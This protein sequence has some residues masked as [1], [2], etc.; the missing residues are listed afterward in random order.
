MCTIPFVTWIAHAAARFTGPRGAVTEQAQQTGCSRQCV[1]DHSQKVLAAVEAQHGGGPTRE[2][3]IQENQAL[4]RENAQLWDWLFQTIEFPLAKQQEFAVTALAMGLSL[5][6]TLVLLALLSG[7]AAAPG[8]SSVHRWVQAA[9]TAAG[10]V[11]KRLDQAARTSVLV[12]CLDEIFFHRRPVLVGVEPQS[13]VW[14]LATKAADRKGSTWSAALQPWTALGYVISD[15]GTGLQAGIDQMNRHRQQT[16]G[17]PM[18]KGLDVFHTKQ[19]AHRVLKVLWSR[20]ERTWE[21]AEAASRA[22][23]E[24]RRQGRDARGPAPR[25]RAAWKKAETAFRRYEQGEAAWKCAEPALS[26]FRPDGQLNDRSWA[27]EQLAAALP[28][29]SG[30]DWSKVR[31]LLQVPE[32]FTFLD[33]LHGALGQ[34]AVA[35]ELLGASVHLWWLRRQRRR[36]GDPAALGGYRQVAP[37]VQQLLCQRLDPN[38]RESYRRVA[39]VLGRAVRASGAVECMN[40]VLRMHQCRHRTLT[41]GMLDLKR[42][43]WNTRAFRGGKRRGRCPYEHLG[44]VLPSYRF[45]SL[46]Q[47]E[48]ITAL[49]EAKAKAKGIAA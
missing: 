42:L 47:D 45:W 29:L 33:R 36:G 43:Y 24:A 8:R 49:D 20:A 41:Q 11:L 19:E 22:R 32:S 40:S 7:A 30:S 17:A 48:L 14:F 34:L 18:E 37:L 13:M 3:L 12:G 39:S 1:Y 46:L 44:L 25:A 6:Q 21:Q 5:N 9:G 31:G 35:D 26:L 27:Q 38:W 23:D 4:R 28:G 16:D 10:A 15:A 2:Q